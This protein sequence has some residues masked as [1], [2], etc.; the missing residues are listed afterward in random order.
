MGET[1]DYDGNYT[2]Y[3]GIDPVGIATAPWLLGLIICGV[4]LL[5]N[6]FTFVLMLVLRDHK[7]SHSNL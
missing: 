4:G 1:Y 6:L 7:K 5:G 2:D 3:A